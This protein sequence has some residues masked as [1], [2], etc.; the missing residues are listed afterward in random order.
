MYSGAN[1]IYLAAN[2]E[3]PSF[4]EVISRLV[5]AMEILDEHNGGESMDGEDNIE[6]Q[7]RNN[8]SR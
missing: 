7:P 6:P 2:V 4:S 8:Q 1:D 3:R 5:I